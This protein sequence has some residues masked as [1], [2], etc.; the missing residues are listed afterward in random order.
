MPTTFPESDFYAFGIAASKSFLPRTSEENLF[1]PLERRR[2][3]EWPWQAVRYRYRSC[4]EC[5]DEF[6][7]LLVN[8]SRSW[9]NGWGDEELLYKL[10]RCIYVFF[11]GALSVFDSFAFSLYF[12]GNAL[13]PNAFPK[14]ANPRSITRSTTAATFTTTFRQARITS[15]FREF[16]PMPNSAPLIRCEI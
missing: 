16:R 2:H 6:K 3:F 13:Q 8:P 10:E 14:I 1:D 4:D 7:A 15:F 9:Q 5:N 11:M 12:Y